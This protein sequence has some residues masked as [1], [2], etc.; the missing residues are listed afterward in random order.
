MPDNQN[1]DY[2]KRYKDASEKGTFTMTDELKILTYII[3]K[4]KFI[5]VSEYAR[6]KNISPAGALKRIEAGNVMYVLI[7][8]N[9]LIIP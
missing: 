6:R 3:E 1:I 8:G 2:F 5:T 4:Y 9:K 7:A